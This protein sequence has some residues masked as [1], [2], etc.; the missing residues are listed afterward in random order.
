M[1]PRAGLDGCG[2]AG[3]TGIRSPD[4]LTR[5]ESLHRLSYPGHVRTTRFRI[6]NLYSLTTEC[7]LSVLSFSG[8]YKLCGI[9]MLS[10]FFLLALQPTV[11]LYFSAL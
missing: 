6:K 8:T 10:F 4:R 3:L 2:K 9:V 5:S 7:G 1:G 11:G